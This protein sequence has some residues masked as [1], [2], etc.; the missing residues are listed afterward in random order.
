MLKYIRKT[1]KIT[2]SKTITLLTKCYLKKNYTVFLL[3]NAPGAMQNIDRGAFILYLI[4]KAK[5][6]LQFCIS[7]SLRDSSDEI[8]IK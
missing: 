7:L 8:L 1:K 5:K 4:C 2:E 3:I 6:S